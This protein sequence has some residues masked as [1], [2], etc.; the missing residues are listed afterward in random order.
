MSDLIP[1]KDRKNLYRDARSNTI[2]NADLKTRE[3]AREKLK[4][5]LEAQ[6][7]KEL[8]EKR[9][10]TLEQDMHSIKNMLSK[11]LDKLG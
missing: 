6:Q 4:R 3:L 2:V 11:I 5:S 10:N 8:Q 7:Q 9:I 1:V